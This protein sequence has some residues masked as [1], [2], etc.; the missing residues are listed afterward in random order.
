MVLEK[1]DVNLLKFKLITKQ[2]TKEHK[3]KVNA[4]SF[5][6]L[7]IFESKKLFQG[8]INHVL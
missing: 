6:C 3:I 2:Q 4:T 1:S 8:F 5:K 7:N